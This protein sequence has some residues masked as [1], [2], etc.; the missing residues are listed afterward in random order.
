M[1]DALDAPESFLGLSR[2]L[3]L[4]PGGYRSFEAATYAE[5]AGKVVTE[6]G[7]D[8]FYRGLILSTATELPQPATLLDP[9]MREL[10]YLGALAI[11]GLG[12]LGVHLGF[13][14]SA[15]GGFFASGYRPSPV[16]LNLLWAALVAHGAAATVCLG[17][18]IDSH[19]H[20]VF[21]FSNVVQS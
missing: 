9:G 12:F 10:S 8:G 17:C 5:P 18:A 7:P 6:T 20:S 2:W 16:S 1:D 13:E 19:L 4:R 15:D 21:L 14:R 11:D 3:L